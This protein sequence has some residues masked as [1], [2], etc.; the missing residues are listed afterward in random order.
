MLKTYFWNARYK[1]GEDIV[2]ISAHSMEDARRIVDDSCAKNGDVI[3][4]IL[5][6][7]EIPKSEKPGIIAVF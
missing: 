6:F 5:T 7:E 2:I 4:E 3:E 1:K